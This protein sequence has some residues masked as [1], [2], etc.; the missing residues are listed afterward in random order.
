ML[1]GIIHGQQLNVLLCV[2]DISICT[3]GSMW[4]KIGEVP[5][6]PGYGVVYCTLI[7]WKFIDNLS[8][9]Q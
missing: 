6:S 7:T 3:A 4:M 9:T 2:A 1:Y 8:E 5:T